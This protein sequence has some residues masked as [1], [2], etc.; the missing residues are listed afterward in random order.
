[1]RHLWLLMV[2]LALGGACLLVWTSAVASG[3][4]EPLPGVT[5]GD[6]PPPAVQSVRVVDITGEKPA[7]SRAA[8]GAVADAWPDARILQLPLPQLNR[9]Y[10]EETSWTTGTGR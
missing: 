7:S 1:V 9:L 10:P 3:P 4:S 8:N 6:R 2:V 5:I